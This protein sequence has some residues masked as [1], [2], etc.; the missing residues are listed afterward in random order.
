MCCVTQR[1]LDVGH[2]SWKIRILRSLFFEPPKLEKFTSCGPPRRR[3]PL[4]PG[5]TQSFR[6]DPTSIDEAYCI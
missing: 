1:D 5:W 4:I 2:S 3:N 6:T